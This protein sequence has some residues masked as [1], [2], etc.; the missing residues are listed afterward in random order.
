L[1][2]PR[3]IEPKLDV[4][5]RETLVSDS[6]NREATDDTASGVS[7]LRNE[8]SRVAVIVPPREVTDW[9]HLR[10]IPCET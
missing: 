5:P 2:R 6:P 10:G 4:S 3:R 9:P 7:R 1:R 8:S